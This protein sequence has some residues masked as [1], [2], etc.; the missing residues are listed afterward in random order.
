MIELETT[1]S[2]SVIEQLKLKIGANDKIRELLPTDEHFKAM[3][4]VLRDMTDTDKS[5]NDMSDDL[6]S[7]SEN[8]RK[9][10]R[11]Y[12]ALRTA[13][14]RSK[15]DKKPAKTDFEIIMVKV[16]KNGLSDAQYNAIIAQC[17][18]NQIQ[19]ELE[20]ASA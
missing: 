18:A 20:T 16:K 13:K 2:D 11:Y 17:K 3:V 14:S 10:L 5:W 19:N 7:L 1:V 12:G 4:K 6:A 15:S 8:D 9:V